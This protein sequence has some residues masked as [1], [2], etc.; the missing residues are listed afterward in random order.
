VPK[1]LPLR[2][3]A[4]AGWSAGGRGPGTPTG[5]FLARHRLAPDAVRAYASDAAA[6]AAV[7]AG[8]GVMLAVAHSVLGALRCGG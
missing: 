1:C 3:P 7:G 2:W 6:L 8:A 5:D 4:S